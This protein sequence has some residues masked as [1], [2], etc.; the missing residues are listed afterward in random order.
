MRRSSI[1]EYPLAPRTATLAD[2]M[3]V[4]TDGLEGLWSKR[5][6][7]KKSGSAGRGAAVAFLFRLA[8]FL[9][10]GIAAEREGDVLR[11]P[12]GVAEGTVGL[13]FEE[14]AD[15]EEDEAG[16]AAEVD[17]GVEID[18]GIHEVG[19]SVDGEAE[20]A[21]GGFEVRGGDPAA[22]DAEGCG[23]L[24]GD[25]VGDVFAWEESV[26]DGRQGAEQG[27]SEDIAVLERGVA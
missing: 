11:V 26:D 10:A 12:V 22:G 24:A 4:G 23:G 3:M 6:A 20:G 1:P 18:V 27:E 9:F 25:A 5:V 13:V 8:G 14:F 2:G 15:G 17:A 16:S 19:G 7:G 21:G